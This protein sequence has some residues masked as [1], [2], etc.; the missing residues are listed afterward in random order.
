MAD[1]F[2]LIPA[3]ELPVTEAKE[4]DVLCVENGEL[5]RKAGANLG[6]GGSYVINV[7][8]DVSIDEEQEFIM[9]PDSYDDFAPI[10]AAGGNV[11]VDLSL[12][13]IQFGKPVRFLVSMWAFVEEGLG[14]GLGETPIFMIFAPNIMGGSSL[15]IAFTNGTWHPEGWEAE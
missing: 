9:L 12:T 3:A 15:N 14:E 7:P 10:L 5:K 4:V 8:A 6:G 2:T 13:D 1:N 11:W